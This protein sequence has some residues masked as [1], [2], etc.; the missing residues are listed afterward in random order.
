MDSSLHVSHISTKL[1]KKKKTPFW[2]RLCQ[3]HM[4]TSDFTDHKTIHKPKLRK[5]DYDLNLSAGW[6]NI[7][8]G[9]GIFNDMVKK[10]PKLGD[11]SGLELTE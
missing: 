1:L 2:F 7:C 8:P 4:K 9:K 6:K 3:T 11:N 10:N 5:S